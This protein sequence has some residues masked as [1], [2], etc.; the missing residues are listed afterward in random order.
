MQMSLVLRGD[1]E[2]ALKRVAGRRGAPLATVAREAVL[3]WLRRQGE[4][5]EFADD[6]QPDDRKN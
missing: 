1:E 6:E 5:P 2:K 3:D 4:L